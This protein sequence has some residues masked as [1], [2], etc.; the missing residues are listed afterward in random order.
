MIW[1]FLIIQLFLSIFSYDF[2][3]IYDD[4]NNTIESLSGRISPNFTMPLSASNARLH[5][6]SDQFDNNRGF[7][8]ILHEGK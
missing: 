6:T 1:L 4:S 5:F 7:K 2:L 8:I 3:T